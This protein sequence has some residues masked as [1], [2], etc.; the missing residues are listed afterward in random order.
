[1][2]F[3]LNKACMKTTYKTEMASVFFTY[4]RHV[5]KVMII[6]TQGMV[7]RNVLRNLI[8]AT[9]ITSMCAEQNVCEGKSKICVCAMCRM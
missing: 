7:V 5:F 4:V 9:N 1:M 3:C 2:F 6:G 8:K